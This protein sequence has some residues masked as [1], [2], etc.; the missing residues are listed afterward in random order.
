MDNG[1]KAFPN[2]FASMLK[3]PLVIYGE[4]PME[5]DQGRKNYKYNEDVILELHSR[6][7]DDQLFIGGVNYVN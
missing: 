5:Y 6:K 1:P 4:N 7:P 3:I 2:K